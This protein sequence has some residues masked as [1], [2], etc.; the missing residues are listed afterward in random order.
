MPDEVSDDLSD[1][2]IDGSAGVVSREIADAF[3]MVHSNVWQL[4]HPA[5]IGH[6]VAVLVVCPG[7][8]KPFARHVWAV[9][10]QPIA[11]EWS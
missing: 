7:A 4:E 9:Y 8:A 3:E 11:V 1:G 2:R 6:V 5:S 10:D